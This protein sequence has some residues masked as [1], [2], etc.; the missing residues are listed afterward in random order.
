MASSLGVVG[1]EV[2]GPKVHRL[3]RR[4]VGGAE[5]DAHEAPLLF[6]LALQIELDR[7]FVE[8]EPLNQGKADVATLRVA[9]LRAQPNDAP[10][11]LCAYR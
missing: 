7:P 8:L 11:A 3:E 1:L 2:E 9:A 5:R 4:P 10:I 6:A